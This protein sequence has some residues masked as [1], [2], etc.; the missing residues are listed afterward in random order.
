[1]SAV[2]AAYHAN[3]SLITP[4]D[5]EAFFQKPQLEMQ[6]IFRQIKKQTFGFSGSLEDSDLN[7]ENRFPG[8]NRRPPEAAHDRRLWFFKRPNRNC[9]E[10]SPFLC[11]N[12][13]KPVKIKLVVVCGISNHPD[14]SIFGTA[15]SIDGKDTCQTFM[16]Y[17][18]LVR[19]VPKC[20]LSKNRCSWF[21]N[22]CFCTAAAHG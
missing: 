14:F 13:K 16:F 3:K 12:N 22:K 1:M 18:T 7:T 8:S 5:L 11:E 10:N 21:Q 4:P 17:L 6:W 19:H 15:A 2:L 9:N 20:I